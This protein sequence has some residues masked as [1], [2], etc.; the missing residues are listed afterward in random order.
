MKSIMLIIS[1]IL[2]VSCNSQL[3][4]WK[5]LNSSTLYLNR[6]KFS[7]LDEFV[8]KDSYCLKNSK[9]IN[10]EATQKDALFFVI[11]NLPE[12]D[13]LRLFQMSKKY[14]W[15]KFLLI[16][17]EISGE[18]NIPICSIIFYRDHEYFGFSIDYYSK[19]V[20]S[21]NVIKNFNIFDLKPEFENINNDHVIISEFNSNYEII[22]TKIFIGSPDLSLKLI[23]IYKVPLG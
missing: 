7:I 19:K 15:E 23:Q 22:K 16:E 17:H 18:L 14:K 21:I 5:S 4:L 12:V 13:I 6:Y 9:I 20:F 8:K 1:G 3:H 2:L 10:N 11:S